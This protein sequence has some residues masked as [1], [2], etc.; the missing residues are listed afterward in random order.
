MTP[1]IVVAL[2]AS[3]ACL[4]LALRNFRSFGMTFQT[5]AWM[6]VAWVIIIAGIAYFA[7]GMAG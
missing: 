6:A 5:K 2:I 3:V 4:G 7:E 1:E